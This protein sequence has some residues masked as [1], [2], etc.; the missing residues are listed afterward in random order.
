[1]DGQAGEGGTGMN[2][3]W[4]EQKKVRAEMMQDVWDHILDPIMTF[5][6]LARGYDEEKGIGLSIQSISAI[7]RLLV[8]GGYTDTMMQCV[9]GTSFCHVTG[10]ELN[11]IIKQWCI[12]TKEEQPHE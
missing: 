11:D 2:N 8:I 6:E 5:A 12:G 3:D 9:V 7:L 1:M 4:K 10:G